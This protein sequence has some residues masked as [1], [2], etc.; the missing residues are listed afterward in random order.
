MSDGAGD[1][2]GPPTLQAAP[3]AGPI[4]SDYCLE[5]VQQRAL[6][7]GFAFVHLNGSRGRIV[8]PLVDDALGVRRNRVVDED[9]DMVFGSQERANV[10][11]QCEVGQ[12]GP[13]DG[14]ADI[15]ISGV[16]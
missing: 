8:L 14:L 9:V 16:H 3:A 12:F 13:L 5:E 2:N 4:V 15:C 1:L 10:T 7:D 6:V 11:V